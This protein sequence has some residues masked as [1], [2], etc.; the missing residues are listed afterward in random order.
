MPA[1]YYRVHEEALINDKRVRLQKQVGEAK[2]KLAS[3]TKELEKRLDGVLRRAGLIG[4]GKM[5]RAA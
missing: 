1:R 3:L 5:K 4:N 2:T